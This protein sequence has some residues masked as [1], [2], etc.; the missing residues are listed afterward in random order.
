MFPARGQSMAEELTFSI[1]PDGDV[2]VRSYDELQQW[3][4]R[5]RAQWDWLARG[6]AETDRYGVATTIQNEWDGVIANTANLRNESRPLQD[7]VGHLGPFSSGP[8]LVSTTVDGAAVLDIRETVGVAAAAFAAGFARAQVN[9]THIK[10]KE[11]LL[12]AVLLG[13]PNLTNAADWHERLKR[14]RANYKMQ[15]RSLL[16]R[17][18]KEAEERNV[19]NVE[20]V[21]RAS[22]V[23][24][25]IFDRKRG[26]WNAV[27][28]EWQEGATAAVSE[29]QATNAAFKELMKL[30]APV[31]YWTNKAGQHQARETSALTR[32]YVFF[33]ITLV[34]M[35][36]AF[37]GTGAFLITHPDTTTSKAPIALYVVVSGGLLLLST[38]AFW[39]GRLLT[40]LYLSEH[41]LRNDAE[42]RA[43]MATTYLALTN[44]GAAEVSERQIVLNAL[45][46]PTPDG[47]VKDEG[48]TDTSLQGLLARLATK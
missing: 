29:I 46:R 14:E 42:E 9:M 31:E 45:F 13:C 44:E 41:H 2:T 27:Q 37:V 33:P 11:D 40:K 5:E 19:A 17:V 4:E 16:E 38:I 35:V 1:G 7:A 22:I 30:K 34:V 24:R 8:L 18:D 47:I 15:T 43:V 36:G 39:I 25:R 26:K 12:G 32:L 48:P 3:L 6:N 10:T 20:L 21:R 23:A 28:G